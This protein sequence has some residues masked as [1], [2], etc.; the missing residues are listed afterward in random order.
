MVPFAPERRCPRRNFPFCL[1]SGLQTNQL[2][3]KM[4]FCPNPLNYNMLQ[5][6]ALVLTLTPE[7][8]E[9]ERCRPP[10]GHK[11]EVVSLVME[12]DWSSNIMYMA[13]NPSH[14]FP[15]KGAKRITNACN[16]ISSNESKT[17]QQDQR[18]ELLQGLEKA[19]L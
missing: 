4:P 16:L 3:V 2:T 5:R 10:P 14:I 17:P 12:F 15:L 8:Y 7:I 6:S 18:H 1:C 9:G 11:K 13:T 19:R